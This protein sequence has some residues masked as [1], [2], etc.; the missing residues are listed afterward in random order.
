MRI[1][2]RADASVQ[3]GTG[4]VMRCLTLAEALRNHG[5]QCAFICRD[6][7]GHLAELIAQKGFE[8]HLLRESGLSELNAEDD[9]TLAHAEWLGASWQQDAEQTLNVLSGASTDWLVIDHYALDARW[10]S[11]V[12]AIAN[13]VMVID[14]IADRQHECDLLL[15]QNLGRM[16]EDYNGLVPEACTRL[17]GPRYALLRS[18]FGKIRER[19]LEHRQNPRLRRILITLGGVDQDNVT[20]Q[21]LDALALSQLPPETEL[22]IVM[23]A[24]APGLEAVR[25]QSETLPFKATVSVNVSDMAERMCLADLC[26]GAAGS[27][28][29][30]RCCLGL[31]SVIVVLAEN[32]RG[33]GQALEQSGAAYLVGREGLLESLGRLL[34]ELV[35]TGGALVSLSSHAKTI[36]DGQGSSRL[37]VELSRN[38]KP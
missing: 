21:V 3:I 16:F 36:C 20:G 35:S 9:T 33:I 14:D 15:D 31:P 11:Q 17:I 29:W 28:S 18:E 27:T 22:D 37:V 25:Q 8:V 12:A 30:E 26:I 32:Q 4:H 23:G 19:S 5:H 13:K 6:H 10:E 34:N 2:F 24:A 38:A 7:P 1:T